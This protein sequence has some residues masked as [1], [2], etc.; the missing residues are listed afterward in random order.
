MFRSSVGGGFAVEGVEK[1]T[2]VLPGGTPG[3]PGVAAKM[4]GW[5]EHRT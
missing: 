3:W 5:S 2:H 4:P 1:R